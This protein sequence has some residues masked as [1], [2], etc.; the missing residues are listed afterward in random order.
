MMNNFATAAGRDDT[1]SPAGEQVPLGS[2][3]TYGEAQRVVDHLSD[4]HFPVESTQIIGSD[5]RMIEQITGRLTWP[6]ALLS[7]AA[8]GVWFGLFVGLLLAILSTAGFGRAMGWS[9]TCG[10]AFGV[11]FAAVGYALTRG[12]RD[13]TSS[14]ATVPSRFEVLVSAEHAAKARAAL[15]ETH[16]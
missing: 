16:R 14:S 3:T 6:R 4:H 12:R 15:S 11:A 10:V 7:G 5:L 9:L 8:S 2:Y 1:F 13:F